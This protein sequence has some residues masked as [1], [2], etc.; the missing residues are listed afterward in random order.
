MGGALSRVE[1]NNL[2][3][4]AHK[5]NPDNKMRRIEPHLEEITSMVSSSKEQVRKPVD[6]PIHKPAYK[7]VEEPVRRPVDEP[8]HK[9]VYRPVE[10][11]MRRPA[12][13]SMLALEPTVDDDK[14]SIP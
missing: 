11:P 10:E 7:A 4:N 8:I 12:K 2:D 6:E 5:N 13:N 9:P 14:P 3:G 1:L